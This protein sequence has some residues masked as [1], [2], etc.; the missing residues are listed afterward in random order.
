MPAFEKGHK[1]VGGRVA[2]TPNKSKVLKD[3]ILSSANNKDL[4]KLY[5]KYPHVYWNL[6]GKC[7]D[8]S[9]EIGQDSEKE[10]V[11]FVIRGYNGGGNTDS[12]TS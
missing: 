2:G 10:P 6:V 3:K 7:I 1:K 11:E 12:S 9:V 4:E 8:R 5:E